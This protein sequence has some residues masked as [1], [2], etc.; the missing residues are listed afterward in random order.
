[1]VRLDWALVVEVVLYGKVCL[2]FSLCL[3]R[4]LPNRKGRR[5]IKPSFPSRRTRARVISE[6]VGVGV[7]FFEARSDGCSVA[8]AENQQVESGT[9]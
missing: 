9:S 6:W 4:G 5:D 7:A 2:P 3:V 1:M 8:A